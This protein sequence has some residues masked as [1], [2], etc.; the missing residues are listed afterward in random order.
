VCTDALSQL[1]FGTDQ[2]IKAEKRRILFRA[3]P[4]I[5]LES[6]VMQVDK[7]EPEWAAGIIRY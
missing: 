3:K 2:E 6:E 1:G 5:S 7:E 4:S